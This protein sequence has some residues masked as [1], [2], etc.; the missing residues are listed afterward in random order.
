MLKI[1]RHYELKKQ[2]LLKPIDMGWFRLKFAKENK[3]DWK[4][5]CLIF[6]KK[7]TNF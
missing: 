3:H 7:K 2:Q 5:Y 6:S 4:F 1:Q